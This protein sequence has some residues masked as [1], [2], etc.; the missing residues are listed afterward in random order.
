MK[1]RSPTV[2][3][4]GNAR[5]FNGAFSSGRPAPQPITPAIAVGA[6]SARPTLARAPPEKPDR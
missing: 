4:Y 6:C 2:P 5:L 3:K 1:S